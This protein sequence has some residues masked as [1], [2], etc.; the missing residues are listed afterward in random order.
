MYKGWL[1]LGGAEIANNTRVMRYAQSLVPLLAPACDDCPDLSVLLGD[2]PYESPMI[3]EA[4]WYDPDIPASGEFAGF[5]MLDITGLTDDTRSAPVVQSVGDGGLVQRSRRA[6]KEARVTG[7]L[8]ASTPAGLEFGKEWLKSVLDSGCPDPASGCEGDD[9]CFLASCPDYATGSVDPSSD[10]VAHPVR[11]TGWSTMGGS[12]V[13]GTFTAPDGSFAIGPEL[14][15]TCDDVI[16][17]WALTPA[18]QVYVRLSTIDAVD[19]VVADSG[20]LLLRRR[21]YI[22]NP[23]FRTTLDFWTPSGSVNFELAPPNRSR[24]EVTVPDLPAGAPLLTLDSDATTAA[25]EPWSA[26]VGIEMDP[27]GLV[28]NN[29]VPNPAVRTVNGWSAVDG[30]GSRDTTLF[31]TD[32]GSY[33]VTPEAD[34]A[35]NIGVVEIGDR[36]HTLYRIN[37]NAGQQ[38]A[39]TAHVYTSVEADLF[40]NYG[41]LDA[42]N[43]TISSSLVSLGTLTA[44]Q[45][46][47]IDTIQTAPPGATG[48]WY[49]VLAR[50]ADAAPANVGD[51]LNV[52]A[53]MVTPQVPPVQYFDG[54]YPDASWTGLAHASPSRWTP[55]GDSADVALVI[56]AGGNEITS[57]PLVLTPGI[58]AQL[59][60]E[61]VVADAAGPVELTIVS[62]GGIELG[63]ALYL[64][65]TVL[66]K[67]PTVGVYFSGET[68]QAEI[69]GYTA[70]WTGVKDRSHS[71]AT[72]DMP[73]QVTVPQGA[74]VQRPVLTLASGGQVTVSSLTASYRDAISPEECL[75]DQIR[76][77]RNVT[78]TSGPRTIQEYDTGC[79]GAMERV[80]FLL[81]AG[82]PWVYQRLRAE[83]ATIPGV[84][85]VPA[86]DECGDFD[87]NGLLDALRELL[88]RL[89]SGGSIEEDYAWLG[90]SPNMARWNDFIVTMSPWFFT[91]RTQLIDWLERQIANPWPLLPDAVVPLIDP[92]CPVP[93]PPPRP[94]LIEDCVAD[95]GLYERRSVAIP[96][97]LLA[98]HHQAV[99]VITLRVNSPTAVRQARIRFWPDPLGLQRILDLDPCSWCGDFLISFMPGRSEFVIDGMLERAISTR[100]M[101][102][103]DATHLLYG[104]DGGPMTWPLLTC[105]TPYIMTVDTSPISSDVLTHSLELVVRS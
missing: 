13:G 41:W 80:E 89:Q 71:L 26:R 40:I 76:T 83:F 39:L 104:T 68:P 105:G 15:P 74:G 29:L 22:R 44:G 23:T 96:G 58:P 88:A 43:G 31:F 16:W 61:N 10:P 70:S 91:Q 69:P 51:T 8:L 90:M 92:D 79:S 28:W 50:R 82:V 3:D 5:Y 11:M 103:K 98:P 72:L 35:V 101:I 9:L 14:D 67:A 48:V 85:T 86:Q 19:T 24:L 73:V 64:T 12:W 37:V 77:L 95:V 18:D 6:T 78:A 56:N 47:P 34:G 2:D 55:S 93:P 49:Q 62:G 87:V 36:A 81:T 63:T 20:L 99:P 100:N 27:E 1:Q 75:E 66:E 57:P 32:S 17:S 42:A 97:S 25:G 60:L 38:Y 21:N 102:R 84:Q 53:A 94:P 7:V 59:V 45:W 52:D 65:R 46:W 54:T 4:A 33:R 30:T